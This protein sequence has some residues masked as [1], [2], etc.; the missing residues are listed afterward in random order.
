MISQHFIRDNFPK[1]K[2][3]IV[4]GRPAIGKTSFAISLAIS[5][6]KRNKKV[7]YLS[8][9]MDKEQLDKRIIL[10]NNHAATGENFVICDTRAAKV[11]DVRRLARNQSFDYILIDYIQLM[12]A[13]DQESS[14]EEEVSS[15]VCDL[16]KLAR[17]LDLPII[18]LSQVN[19]I[20]NGLREIQ[21]DD[22]TDTNVAIL[23]R[24]IY[25]PIQMVYKSYI[26]GKVRITHFHYNLDSTEVTDYYGDSISG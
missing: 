12:S 23:F 21:P 8:I 3:T 24:D 13:D 26:K 19:R 16:K 15:V 25:Q 10:Q 22:L 11:G 5:M 2:L 17:E 9:E 20:G 18:A 7:V 4:G 6:A 14:R 1:G